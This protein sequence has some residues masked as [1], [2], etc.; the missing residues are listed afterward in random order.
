MSRTQVVILGTGTPNAEAD[1]VSSSLAVVVDDQPYLVDCGHGVVQR[2]VQAQA[3]GKIAWDTTR[4]T[5]LF[6]TH[7]HA[8]HTVGLPDLLFTPWIHG[9]SDPIEAIGPSG[10]AD[11]A[12][13]I[14]SAYC[15]NIREHLSA[16]PATAKGY[17]INV[18]DV[19]DGVCYQDE[20][21]QVEAIRADHGDLEAWSYK[22]TT[23]DAIIVVSGD[24]KPVPGFAAWARDCDVLI[25]EV[26]SSAKF[27]QRLDAW[28]AYHS[29][30]HTSTAELT[31]LAR[32][33][34]PR[35]LLLYHQ[36]FWGQS[37]DELV[38]E[39]RAHYDGQ[40]IST[41]DLDVFTL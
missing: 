39:I 13:H 26:Y 32:S 20:R 28:Q 5:R 3:S 16:H 31:A 2:V 11:M 41:N 23:P 30:V 19:Q 38:A 35:L 9:R 22:F 15:E 6:V 14:L 10:L 24:T 27:P 34:R 37:A 36:L 7:L 33:I 17:R 40:V 29:R 25:H 12:S 18:R 21:I 8:D 4:L 1:R